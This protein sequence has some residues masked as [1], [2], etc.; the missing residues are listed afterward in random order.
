VSFRQVVAT[1]YGGP[2]NLEVRE[3]DPGR[4]ADGQVLIDV[5]AA[6]V[7]AWDVKSYSGGDFGEDPNALPI[8][9]GAEVSGVVAA[10]GDGADGPGGPI[11]VGDEVIAWPVSGGYADRVVA[12]AGRVVPKP[13]SMSWEQAA[14]LML[15]GAAAT[16]LVVATD[17]HE[18]DVALLH[19]AAGGVGLFAAQLA[20]QRGARVIG[21]A[22]P[23]DHEVLRALGVEPLDFR[24]GLKE[25]V[26]RLA[27]EGIDV[28]LD[29]VGAEPVLD[30]SLDVAKDESRIA[31]LV[32]SPAATERGIKQLGFGE[33]A[34][35]GDAIR[36]AARLQ[37]TRAF[38]DGWLTIKVADTFSLEDAADAHRA[39]VGAHGAGKL[40]LIT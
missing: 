27:P 39:M 4:P 24:A 8:L 13:A 11:A 40:V 5:R 31:T 12:D 21:S 10:V 34:D 23:D 3:H 1:G 17:V 14:G 38:E 30:L 32:P 29:A 28:V 37:L 16:H 20:R 36:S 35:P 25:N 22:L 15:T 19:G 18:G 26:K 2:E 33:H 6:G 7:N 9:L